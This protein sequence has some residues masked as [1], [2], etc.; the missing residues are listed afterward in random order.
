MNNHK[1]EQLLKQMI[2]ILAQESGE[3]VSVEG[4]TLEELKTLWRGFVNVRQ[5]K[6]ASADY[7]VL[8]NEYLQEY[9]APRVQTLADCVPTANDQIKLYYGD[10]CELQVDA[11]VN[12]A[13]SR[14]WDVLFQ[15]TA[16]L[17]MRFILFQELNFEAFAI[18]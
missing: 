2:E 17:I 14:C 15:T 1:E 7:I 8:E 18:I 10:L 3:T 12:A 4:K 5:P 11:I 6:E 13:N 9:H 16:V